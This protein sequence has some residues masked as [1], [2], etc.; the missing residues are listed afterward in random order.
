MTIHIDR[1]ADN[2]FQTEGLLTLRKAD[3][4]IASFKTLE[5]PWRNNDRRVSRIP[6]GN[7][8]AIK[9]TSP[10]FGQTLWILD[11]P[12]RSEILIHRGNFNRDTLG[13]I[14][15]GTE[16]RDIDKDGQIDVINSVSAMNELLSLIDT[17][18]VDVVVSDLRM[19]NFNK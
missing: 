3:R 8:K 13:C 19:M 16:F 2:E 18:S 15:V 7:Y 14:L 6:A 17:D 5:L 10:R 12:N 9:H 11:V 4:I 1:I